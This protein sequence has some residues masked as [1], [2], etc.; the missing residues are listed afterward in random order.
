MD[1]APEVRPR[2]VLRRALVKGVAWAAPVVATSAVAP[3]YA[4]S[5]E[6]APMSA[7]EIQSLF[8]Y[9]PATDRQTITSWT[10]TLSDGAPRVFYSSD[11]N[12]V[13]NAAFL[14]D[15][16]GTT[17]QT[18]TTMVSQAACLGPGT[19]TFA[20]TSSLYQKNSRKVSLTANVLDGSTNAVLG[21]TVSFKTASGDTVQRP[22]DQIVI[23]V[24][25]RTQI[26]FRFRWVIDARGLLI[27]RPADDIGVSAVRVRKTA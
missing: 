20:F 14:Q 19:Y 8:A 12:G 25:Q 24:R 17:D 27:N 22:E 2:T 15:D 16:P 11:A 21:N 1:T 18:T 13:A 10:Q 23:T 26:H 7:D 4:A 5:F 9:A 6:C 3:A